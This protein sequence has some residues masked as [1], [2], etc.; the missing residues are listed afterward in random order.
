MRREWHD[1]EK[2]RSAHI[3]PDTQFATELSYTRTHSIYPDTETLRLAGDGRFRNASTIVADAPNETLR[4]MSENEA[5][6]GRPCVAL[7]IRHRLLRNPQNGSLKL[8][9]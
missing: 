5:D 6:S 2:G 4:A 3:R 7:D 1:R 9:G 8:E